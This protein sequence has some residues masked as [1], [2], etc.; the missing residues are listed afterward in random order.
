MSN[1]VIK[2]FSRKSGKTI[3]YIESVWK[4]LKD[5]YGNDYEKIVGTLKKILKID[6]IKIEEIVKY[7]AESK[8]NLC[9]S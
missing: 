4:D 9:F 7:I 8:R 6:E 3:S 5:E 2:T 1:Q